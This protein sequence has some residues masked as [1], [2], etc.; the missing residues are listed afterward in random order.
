ML[1]YKINFFRTC[2]LLPPEVVAIC[3]VR[4]INSSR[5]KYLF[6]LYEWRTKQGEQEKERCHV[7]GLHCPNQ[8]LNR[9]FSNHIA[10]G[11]TVHRLH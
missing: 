10:V 8:E 11:N 4:H 3:R 1:I 2:F 5:R 7:V 9:S 6:I